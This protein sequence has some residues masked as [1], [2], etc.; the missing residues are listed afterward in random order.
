MT[1]PALSIYE[2]HYETM[3]PELLGEDWQIMWHAGKVHGK[4]RKSDLVTTDAVLPTVVETF[5]TSI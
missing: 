5:V 4:V 2:T 1:S 3:V